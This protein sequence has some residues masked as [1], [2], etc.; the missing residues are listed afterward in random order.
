MIYL[1]TEIELA[2]ILLASTAKPVE[3]GG[4]ESKLNACF[5]IGQALR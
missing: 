3:R 2:C 5:A 1:D 4:L